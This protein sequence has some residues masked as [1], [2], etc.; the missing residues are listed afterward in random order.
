MFRTTAS[1]KPVAELREILDFATIPKFELEKE[2]DMVAIVAALMKS[3]LRELVDGIIPVDYF[4]DFKS[5]KTTTDLQNILK[6]MP[7]INVISLE[8][9]L[10][11][12]FEL[13]KFSE[14]NKM[15][16]N[17]IGIVFGPTLFKCP[18]EGNQN[19]QLYLIESMQTKEFVV[20][21]MQDIHSL[22]PIKGF[23]TY[24]ELEILNP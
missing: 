14:F 19:A 17:N 7:L 23:V 2:N 15:T 5:A 12:L 10:R 20:N 8:Y 21:M 3:W 4:N 22:F 6:A 9:I 11:F 1:S 16:P 24:S 13:S 18:S